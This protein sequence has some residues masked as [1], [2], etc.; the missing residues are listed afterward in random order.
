MKKN[1]VI[2]ASLAVLAL[3]ACQNVKRELGVGRNSPDEFMVVKRAP[4]SLPPD[5]TLRPP[6]S[7]YV[8]P[9]S[10]ITDQA[11]TAVLGSS[12]AP[13]KAGSGEEI[14]MEKLGVAAANPEIRSIINQENGYIALENR[15]LTDKLIFWQNDPAIEEK[16]PASVVNP[17]KETARI[18][19]NEE[20]G[21]PVN[22]GDVPVIEK[23][24]GTIDKIF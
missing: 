1:L 6:S 20:E 2:V 24:K 7:D 23:K 18:K 12:A 4:L 21:K 8:S 16:M 5:Y 14:L 9:A 3:S 22:D 11:R 15:T 19:K 13:A 10:E 17:S